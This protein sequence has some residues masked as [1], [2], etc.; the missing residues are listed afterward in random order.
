MKP[1]IWLTEKEFAILSKS[2]K[3]ERETVPMY[4]L[5]T[6]DKWKHFDEAYKTAHDS[7]RPEDWFQAALLAQQVR[8]EYRTYEDPDGVIHEYND[9]S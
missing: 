5:P 4:T 6:E 3:T 7:S 8:N 2:K 9:K 1:A